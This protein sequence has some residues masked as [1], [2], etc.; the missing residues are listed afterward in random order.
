MG[1]NDSNITNPKVLEFLNGFYK[2]V[3]REL[4]D[5]RLRA[6][7]DHVPIILRDT[8]NVLRTLLLIARPVRI[9]EFG[10]AVGYSASF[11]A[12]VCGSGSKVVSLELKEETAEAAREN[13]RNLGY[14]SRITVVTGDAALTAA[15]QEGPFD[16]V[17]IDAAKSHYL[18]YWNAVIDK[19]GDGG[20]IICDNILMSGR[21]V[22]EEYDP[23][24]KYRTN[25]RKMN[26][27]LSYIS[28]FENADTSFISAGDGMSVSVIR[29]R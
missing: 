8:E 28:E 23:G 17:F 14:E 29:K 25:I 18:D 5:L 2:P 6:E 22:S 4:G 27:F 15:E 12:E 24:R 20:L 7:A 10:T 11:F 9:L 3:T 16:L 19:V 1:I 21:T 13:I 26:E